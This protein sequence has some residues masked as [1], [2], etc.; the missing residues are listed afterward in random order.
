[1]KPYRSRQL[2]AAALSI[3]VVLSV[4]AWWPAAAIRRPTPPPAAAA[5]PQEAGATAALAAIRQQARIKAERELDQADAE[6]RRAVEHQLL[7]ID[8]LFDVARSGLPR[9]ADRVLGLEGQ[10]A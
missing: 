4:A 7:A 10:L 3:I 5:S 6:G 8:A 2:G 1:M 9:F